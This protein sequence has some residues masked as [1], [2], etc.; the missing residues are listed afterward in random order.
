MFKISLFL[1]F[2]FFCSCNTQRSIRH[3]AK[4]NDLTIKT[5][6]SI[7]LFN[8]VIQIEANP[9]R[10]DKEFVYLL[11]K[12]DSLE[13]VSNDKRVTNNDF[14]FKIQRV[15]NSMIMLTRAT[16]APRYYTVD[17]VLFHHDFAIAKQTL[18][19]N[20]KFTHSDLSIYHFSGDTLITSSYRSHTSDLI[21]VS[22]YNRG[23]IDTATLTGNLSDVSRNPK[24]D[25]QT[26]FKRHIR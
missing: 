6:G 10:V 1:G 5:A 7:T 26:F 23:F 18:Y 14:I 24:E 3:F 9:E 16:R 4:G 12:G 22:K 8:G 13:Y 15:S 20:N 11:Y 19:D 25:R 21:Q 2:L 17:T